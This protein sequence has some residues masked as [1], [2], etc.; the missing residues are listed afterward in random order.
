MTLALIEPTQA[1]WEE[2]VLRHPQGSLLQLPCWGDLKAA[3]GWKVSRIAVVAQPPAAAAPTGDTPPIRAGAQV[4]IRTRYLVSVVYVPRGPLWSGD[5]AIDNLLLQGLE[6][7]ARRRRAVFLRLEP[8]LLEH[9]PQADQTHSRLLLKR[10]QPTKPIQPRSTIHLALDH[11]ADTLFANMSKGHRADIRR[12]SR[13]GVTLRTGSTADDL[14]VFHAIMQGTGERVGFGVHAPSYYH[15]AHTLT[16][17][18]SLL[19]IAEQ[20]G[21]PVA[22][23][24]VFADSQMGLYLYSG[25]TPAGLKAGANH[26][27]QWQAIQWAQQ[28]GCKWYDFWGIPDALGQAVT[29]PA[30]SP[31]QAALEAAA[32]HDPLI[33][34]Y[35]FKKGFGGTIVRYLPAYDQVYLPPLYAVW[36]HRFQ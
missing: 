35:R 13:Q 29:L 34:V 21:E 32:Q 8:P 2:F 16:G 1:V 3:F 20:E 18:R 30:D 14:A 24:M 26:L 7:L 4:L 28:Q 17:P 31:K 36:R 11:P 19:L 33:G 15:L 5:P 22:S 6:Q 25:A 23:H 9:E 12:A 10:F 27:L